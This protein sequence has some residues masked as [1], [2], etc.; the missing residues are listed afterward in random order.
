MRH[1][2]YPVVCCLAVLSACAPIPFVLAPGAAQVRVTNVAADVA[3][4]SPVGNIQVPSD[5]GGFVSVGRALGQ[6]KNQAI[7]FG[8]NAAFVTD[9]TLDIPE[10]GIAYH[11]PEQR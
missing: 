11:C 9:G 8:G 4:C 5:G 2:R 10:A 3:G 7:G 6:L 1:A